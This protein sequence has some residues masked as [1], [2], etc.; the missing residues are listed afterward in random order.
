MLALA[1]IGGCASVP[2]APRDTRPFDVL[3]RVL[4]TYSGGAVTSNLRW[5]HAADRDE[6]WLMTPT[7]QTLAQVLDTP[8]GA[9]LTRADQQ[10]FRADSVEALTQRAL[11]WPLPLTTLQYWMRGVAAPGSDADVQERHKD[12]RLV[13]FSQN[14]WQVKV[15]YD[16]EGELA[17][18]ARRIDL[19]DGSNEIRF[20]IDTWRES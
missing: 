6:I 20:V 17:G 12:G 4:V 18:K 19:N 10:Q 2:L 11:G 15:T 14:G 5:E 3:G 1:I 7:G 16:G 9:I 13:A 8:D